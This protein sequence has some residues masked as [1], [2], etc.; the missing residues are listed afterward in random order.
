MTVDER[1][2]TWGAGVPLDV[3]EAALR[4][5]RAGEIRAVLVVHNETSTGVTSDVVGVRG[6]LDRAGHDALLL[7][8]AVS[9]LA[10]IEFRFDAW[11]VDVALTGSQKGLMLPP[12]IGLLAVSERALTA[13][14]TAR[15][16]R[17]YLDWGPVIENMARGYFPYTPAT[18]MLYGLREAL[19]LLHEEGLEAV[20]ARHARHAGAVR[21]AVEAW[22]LELLCRDP[23]E[24]SN[25]ASAVLVPGDV[26]ADDVLAAAETLGLSLGTGLSK[27]KG[28]VFRIG[29]LG[30][31]NELEVVATLAGSELALRRAG[32]PVALGSGV[33]AALARYEGG[34]AL[35]SA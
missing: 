24:R 7:V 2:A 11:R 26:N 21:A 23:A 12:G 25:T 13:S 6:A 35:S 1:E 3:L 16:P 8:D 20:Y 34:S 4:E 32:V 14:R 29:H 18:L 9:S 15:T 10:S 28:R 27:L 5:D 19:R 30:S 31:L 33:T 22:E 17:F